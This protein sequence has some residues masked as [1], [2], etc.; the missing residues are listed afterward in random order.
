VGFNEECCT[1]EFGFLVGDQFEKVEARVLEAPK[2]QN[3]IHE[4]E[5][6]VVM[7]QKDVWHP[8]IFVRSN[9]LSHWIILNL[10]RFTKDDLRIFTVE[11]QNVGKTLGR[12]VSPPFPPKNMYGNSKI[13]KGVVIAVF[14]MS[15]R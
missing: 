10:N 6:N 3:N 14:W 1:K 8:L 2:L 4:G 12:D 9:K 7:P 15:S 11:I 5:K 13:P